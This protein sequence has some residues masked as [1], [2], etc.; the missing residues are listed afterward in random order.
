MTVKVGI[1]GF[2]RIGHLIY[3]NWAQKVIRG[4]QL[5][6]EIVAANDVTDAKT[7]CHT[8]KYDTVYREFGCSV[9]EKTSVINVPGLQTPLNMIS[10]KD[11][12]ELPW[13]DMGV[14]F[15]IEATGKFTDRG[16][17]E[18]H[19]KA[20]AKRVIISAP[21]KGDIDLTVVHGVNHEL[22]DP[23]K[24]F[25]MSNASCTTN[26]LAPIAKVLNDSLGIEAGLMTTVHS[27]TADQRLVDGIHSDFRRARA[28]ACNM[29]PTTT[30]AAKAVG[31]VIPEL[32]GKLTG[33]A[34]RVPTPS[35]SFVDLVCWL[36]K[37][38]KVEEVNEMFKAAS[39]G[40]MKG[41][42][43]YETE[44]KVSSDFIAME[45]SSIVDPEYTMVVGDKLVKILGWYDNE[46]GYVHTL[47]DVLTYMVKK[48]I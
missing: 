45:Y 19:L 8:L 28:A 21:G 39:E 14:E 25:I 7:L 23:G 36:K 22:Y 11:P 48:G 46:W 3:R 24:H 9:D 34:V 32:K 18:K 33:F 41:I 38:T 29:I 40:A 16:G 17:C 43:R 5:G 35:V 47:T 30:G 13:K 44:P 2:G 6:W 1:N 12:L 15:V 42:I 27:Y 37:A 26:C 31:L 4:E 20:G 10:Y